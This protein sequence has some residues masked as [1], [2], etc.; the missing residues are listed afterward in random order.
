[1]PCRE[2][3]EVITQ[4]LEGG[5]LPE[6]RV[7]FEEHLE[8]CSA[9]RLYLDQMEEVIRTLGRIEVE[10]LAPEVQD[11]LVAAFSGWR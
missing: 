1:M 11:E 9:C 3:V 10:Q 6:D 8:A 7:R 5:L 4:Y 2:I